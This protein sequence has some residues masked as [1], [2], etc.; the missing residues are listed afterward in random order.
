MNL[1]L[2]HI[3][4]FK[5]LSCDG[6]IEIC[7]CVDK[8]VILFDRFIVPDVSIAVCIK[9]VAEDTRN[10]LL[11]CCMSRRSHTLIFLK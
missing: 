4:V 7:S 8:C 2:E 3:V 9:Y 1:F 11:S 5:L 10:T 6:Y